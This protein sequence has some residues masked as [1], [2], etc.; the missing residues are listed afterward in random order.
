MEKNDN[1]K[2]PLLRSWNQWYALVVIVLV[3]L[4][5][6]FALITEHFA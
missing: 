5:V 3:V 1:D 4:I 2:I 6:L